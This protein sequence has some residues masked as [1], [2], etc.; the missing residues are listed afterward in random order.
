MVGELARG[1][2][3][4]AG[5]SGAEDRSTGQP[6]INPSPGCKVNFVVMIQLTF[7]NLLLLHFRCTIQTLSQIWIVKPCS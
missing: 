3:A 7:L 1:S 4:V 2:G 6:E 5:G